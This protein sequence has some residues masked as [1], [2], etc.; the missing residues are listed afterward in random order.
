MT[1]NTGAEEIYGYGAQEILGRHCSLFYERD[2]IQSGKPEEGLKAA[3]ETGR[4]E[5]EGWRLRKDGS[6]FWANVVITALMDENNA[7]RGF[8]KVTR[9]MTERKRAADALKESGERLRMAV[10]AARMHTWDWDVQTGMVFRS[11]HHQVIYG[12]GLFASDCTYDSFLQS[13]H[14]E[15]RKQIEEAVNRALSGDASYRA[16]FR[17]MQ[18]SGGIRWLEAQGQAY[19]DGLG[20]AVRMMGVTQDITERKKAEEEL[21]QA[22]ALLTNR[23]QELVDTVTELNK[24][25]A[26]LK[27]AQLQLIR[28]A[29]FESVGQLA[30][31]VAHEVKNPLAIIL[32]G[33]QYLAKRLATADD[34]TREVLHD[35]E[36]AIKRADSIIIG[37]LDF[38]ASQTISIKTQDLN[39]IIEQA[40]ALI[41]YELDK[42]HIAVDK[43]LWASLPPLQLDRQK[44]EQA[45]IN[46]FL[47][48]IHAMPGGGTLSVSTSV[49]RAEHLHPFVGS[50]ETDR[51]AVGES[52]V[53]AEIEDT[54]VGIPADKLSKIFDPFFSGLPT[55]KG[56]GLGLTVTRRIIDLH[57]GT[58]DIQNRE[59]GGVKVTI[60]L[61]I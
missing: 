39:A 53:I 35:I 49:T 19:R 1:W 18:P 46:L 29:K 38:S 26:A 57:G 58:I 11:G 32:M 6:R 54:G 20:K 3:A 42:H 9:D 16:T 34:K 14:P 36:A 55:G 50:R 23:E 52:I 30:A 45:L 48:A 51:F 25:H 12:S 2:A 22:H 33:T 10:D 47:N 61:K 7:L 60:A 31:G 40:I 37:L 5:D 44:M 43:T 24:S 56:T 17:I 4:F 59:G 15:D 13:V 21:R 41:K 27:T 28:A 8:A